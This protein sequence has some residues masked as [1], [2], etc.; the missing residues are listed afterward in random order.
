[1][2]ITKQGTKQYEYKATSFIGEHERSRGGYANSKTVVV[3]Q[4]SE[5]LDMRKDTSDGTRAY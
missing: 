1:M 2:I 3:M 4:T 5:A